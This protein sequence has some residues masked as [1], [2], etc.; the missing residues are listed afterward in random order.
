MLNAAHGSGSSGFLSDQAAIGL[1]IGFLALLVG[2]A[3]LVL[4]YVIRVLRRRIIYGMTVS[5]S[6]VDRSVAR[7]DLHI[8][9]RDQEVTDP[10]V[11][12]RQPLPY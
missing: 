9:W 2:I 1:L 3:T 10:H 4:T 12:V 11:L 8:L 6:M 5:A 7:P